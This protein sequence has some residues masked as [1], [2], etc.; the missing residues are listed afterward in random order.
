MANTSGL[1]DKEAKVARGLE[2]F[3]R[4]KVAELTDYHF[5]W[6]WY[7]AKSA[8][9]ALTKWANDQ[10]VYDCDNGGTKS[11]IV[12]V[13]DNGKFTFYHFTHSWGWENYGAEDA[14]VYNEFDFEEVSE[15]EARS[16]V[17]RWWVV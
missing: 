9:D 1:S 4:F 6:D 7:E 5:Q 15:K 8:A 14:H 13:G 10:Y 17:S 12:A 11:V 16:S 2:G 3:R